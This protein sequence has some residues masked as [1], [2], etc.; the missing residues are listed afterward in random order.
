MPSARTRIFSVNTELKTNNLDSTIFSINHI[1]V[2]PGQRRYFH[3]DEVRESFPF[4][5]CHNHNRI[6]VVENTFAVDGVG[7]IVFYK[8]GTGYFT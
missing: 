1:V 4:L 2:K 3:C 8:E 6:R 7:F 5:I